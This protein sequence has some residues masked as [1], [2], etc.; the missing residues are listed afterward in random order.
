MRRE[1]SDKLE[2]CLAVMT[3]SSSDHSESSGCFSRYKVRS[4]ENVQTE[5]SRSKGSS[6]DA[7]MRYWSESKNSSFPWRFDAWV[8]VGFCSIAG[9]D[10]F[11]L[12]DNEIH[13]HFFS[14]P[15]D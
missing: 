7:G 3:A 14:D 2:G 5:C 15:V 6:S 4:I 12:I 13:A 9:K 10:K 8:E 11:I 1:A